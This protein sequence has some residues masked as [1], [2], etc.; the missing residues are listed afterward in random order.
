MDAPVSRSVSVLIAPIIQLRKLSSAVGQSLTGHRLLSWAENAT[1]VDAHN[2]NVVWS[3]G[4][5]HLFLA[6]SVSWSSILGSDVLVLTWLLL[7]AVVRGDQL[8]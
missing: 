2:L 8:N 5:C 6:G 7:N 4:K 3:L 1:T